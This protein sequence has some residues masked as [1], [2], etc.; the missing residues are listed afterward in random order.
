MESK[1]LVTLSKHILFQE[2]DFVKAGMPLS[3][4]SITPTDILKIKEGDLIL[5]AP[6]SKHLAPKAKQ[7][8]KGYRI[9]LAFNVA[10]T[11]PFIPQGTHEN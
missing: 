10:I 2:N 8:H 9:S 6:D 7:K 3:D 5:F 11:H 4:G 1:Y